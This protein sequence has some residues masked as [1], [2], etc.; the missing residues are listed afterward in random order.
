[1]R[2]ED[3][4]NL[5]SVARITIYPGDV[6]PTAT[7]SNPTAAELE[8]RGPDQA[9]RQRRSTPTAKSNLPRPYYWETRMAHCPDPSNP[10]ACHE[11]PLQTFSG[12]RRPEFFA[13]QHE[14]PS[15]IK[16]LLRVSDER[17]LSGTATFQYQPQTVEPLACLESARD[18]AAGGEYESPLALL[19]ARDQ[20]LRNPALGAA[21]ARSSAARPTPSSAG[22]TAAPANTRSWSARRSR[23]TPP[24]TRS[25][26]AHA[27]PPAAIKLPPSRRLRRR[28]D[29]QASAAKTTPSRQANFTFRASAGRRRFQLQARRQAEIGLPLTEDLQEAEARQAHLQGLGD[30][31]RRRPTRRRRSSAGRSCRR[32]GSEPLGRGAAAR[33]SAASRVC[34]A[35]SSGMS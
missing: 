30:G 2:V 23:S 34:Q 21:D 18:R 14:Y 10:T 13:P 7:I 20:R 25:R 24:T 29:R 3:D 32:S 22:R 17:G 1:M 33:Y 31:D 11:H 8:G 35:G 16:V 9:R 26:L 15:Y 12:I 4:E 19:G 6:P 5:S 28:Q 27:G